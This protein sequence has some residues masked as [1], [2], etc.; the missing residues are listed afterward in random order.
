MKWVRLVIL[1]ILVCLVM[2]VPVFAQSSDTVT[3]TATGFIVG[4]PG[5]FTLIY[6]T[7]FQ[8]QIIW[9]KPATA[10]NTM[11]R[12]SYNGFPETRDDGYLV[13]YGMGTSANDTA[14]NLD[15]TATPVYYRAWS[16]D[17]DGVW[18]S[19]YA[20][21][22]IGGIGVTLI[23]LGL[24]ALGLTVAMFLSRSMMLGF[25]AFM[26]WAVLGAY[27]YTESATPWGDWQY[28]LFFASAFGM[29]TFCAVAMYGLREKRDTI[30][31]EELEKGED[32]YIDEGGGK[33]GIEFHTGEDKPQPSQRTRELRERAEKRRKRLSGS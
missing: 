3:V 10:N 4:A 29:T 25:P 19:G 18:S 15:E 32:E 21:G 24:L 1:I 5:D 2:P 12:A 23:A 13:Y 31:D 33:T 26:F 7:D 28:Y 17:S 8:I 20:E 14:V 22:E 16:E 6:I 9:V 27:A 30:G 11:V